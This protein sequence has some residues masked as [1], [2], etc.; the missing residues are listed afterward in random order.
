[1]VMVEQQES[2][3][4]PQAVAGIN[5]DINEGM[6]EFGRRCNREDMVAMQTEENAQARRGQAASATCTRAGAT[7]TKPPKLGIVNSTL[8]KHNS[9]AGS[10]GIDD[11]TRKHAQ[12]H[13]HMDY[14]DDPELM[15]EEQPT[16]PP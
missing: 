15:R 12:R 4:Q 13:N 7:S 3:A 11:P 1:M 14:S 9:E 2:C 16:S 6:Q 10:R 8:E 5:P